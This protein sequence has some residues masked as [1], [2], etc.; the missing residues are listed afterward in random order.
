MTIIDEQLDKSVREHPQ[1]WAF[2]KKL[3]KLDTCFWCGKKME[4]PMI[5][6]GR[7]I[8]GKYAFHVYEVHGMPPEFLE[9]MV[10]EKLVEAY[11]H[12]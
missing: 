7:K 3:T 10:N 5:L 11:Q 9:D 6:P 1:Y 2:A 12:S 4:E 8:S